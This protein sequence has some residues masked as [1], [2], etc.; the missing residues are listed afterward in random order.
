MGFYDR[1]ILPRLIELAMRGR[2]LDRYRRRTIGQAQGR[3]LEI[4]VGSGLNLALYGPTV[5]HVCAIDP[6][7]ELLQ[8]ARQ[9][10]AA[11]RM[12]VLLVRGS[13]ERLP[14]GQHSFDTLV[15]TWT[16]CSIPDPLAALGEAR[17]VL[18]A[19][20]RLLFVEHGLAPEPGVAR[21]QHR[22][23]PVWRRI[24]G[25][26]HLDR[27][28]DELLRAAGF[29]LAAVETGYMPGPRPW[30]FMYEGRAAP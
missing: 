4:G 9:R 12:P 15:T 13:A 19:N 14:F 2:H 3:V 1:L 23:T 17:R 30:T 18:R 22:L 24:A 28:V 7:A 21:W 29:R 16:L 26:C 8:L 5:E 27:P 25:G 11:A 20:G 6:S 10:I